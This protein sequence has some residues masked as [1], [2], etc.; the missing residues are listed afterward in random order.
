MVSKQISDVVDFWICTS[1]FP[2]QGSDV[3]V[4]NLAADLAEAVEVLI[5]VVQVVTVLMK[6]WR[7]AFSDWK[8]LELSFLPHL[9]NETIVFEGNQKLL[10]LM[11]EPHQTAA[12]SVW[13][14]QKTS[15]MCQNDDYDTF[16]NRDRRMFKKATSSSF[17][18]TKPDKNTQ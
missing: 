3:E 4:L 8:F 7:T 12:K 5:Q 16:S 17:N 2:L 9:Q 1:F 18:T 6:F 14:I 15:K 10:H 11:I 13:H